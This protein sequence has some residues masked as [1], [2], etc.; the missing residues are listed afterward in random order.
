MPNARQISQRINELLE[1]DSVSVS[2]AELSSLATSYADLSR[3]AHDR[4]ARCH[5]LLAEGL[6]SEAIQEADLEPSL[7]KL[8][9]AL[10]IKDFR[11]WSDCCQKHNLPL[12]SPLSRHV[13]AE[14]NRGYAAD[15]LVAPLLREYRF[16]CLARRPLTE[17]IAALRGVAGLDQNNNVWNE[18]LV[19]LETHRLDE[20]PVEIERALGNVDALRTI[21]RE[22]LDDRRRIPAPAAMIN[23]VEEGLRTTLVTQAQDQL[24][25]LLPA[26]NE[27][28]TAMDYRVA[29]G[30]LES[31]DATLKSVGQS[32]LHLPDDLRE[33]VQPVMD[34]VQTTS[35]QQEREI[36]F[37][38][39]S[40]H[41]RSLVDSP[42]T[43]EE[44]DQAFQRASQFDLPLPDNLAEDTRRARQKLVL[45]AARRRRNRLVAVAGVGLA[46]VACVGWGI[47]QQIKDRKVTQA[48]NDVERGMSERNLQL[49]HDRFEL[50]AANHPSAMDRPDVNQ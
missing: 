44:L 2:S 50:M 48:L 46:L 11:G 34:W 5:D 12:P 43:L 22:L 35:Q 26:L 30:L 47:N 15:Q 28:Y 9:A 29:R 14:L 18:S 21:Q 7:L 42:T 27:A 41:L 13:A 45:A 20:L 38:Q 1:A 24:R 17:R 49:A 16:R 23:R 4:L 8:V 40:A 6:R 31:W 10:E 36:V 25:T 3:R 32:H 39:E 33:P 19:L 37:R